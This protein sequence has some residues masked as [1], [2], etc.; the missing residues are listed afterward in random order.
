MGVG[1]SSGPLNVGAGYLN[2]HNPNASFFGTAVGA[3]AASNN[4]GSSPVINGYA[5]AQS[6]Q[7][8][9]AGATFWIHGQTTIRVHGRSARGC[10]S[11]P[12]DVVAIQQWRRAE[13]ALGADDLVAARR[14]AG[15]PR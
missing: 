2:A 3:T 8:I 10:V 12:S 4:F 13:A 15:A 14:W 7:I 5:S 6:Q 9:G 1:Y 11:G